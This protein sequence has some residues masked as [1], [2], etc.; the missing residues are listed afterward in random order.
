[1]PETLEHLKTLRRGHRG[2]ITKYVQEAKS[3]L[4]TEDLDEKCQ[5]RTGTFLELLKDKSAI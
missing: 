2:I 3:L 1:M 5:L 4:E